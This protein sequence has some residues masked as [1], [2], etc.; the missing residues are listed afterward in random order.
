MSRSHCACWHKAHHLGKE[1]GRPKDVCLS[2]NYGAT[3]LIRA[4][5]A[6]PIS[7]D[8]GM[9]ILQESK[10]AGLAQTGDNVQRK[11]TYICN[12]CGCCCGMMEAI[13][14]GGIRGAIVTSNWLMKVDLDKCKGCGECA[15][16]CPVDAIAMDEEEVP[17]Q[18]KRKWAV[19]DEKVCL[20]CGVCYP[21]CKS[22]AISMSPRPKRVYTPQT[23]FDQRVAMAIERGKLADLLFDAPERLSHRALRRMIA[24]VEK[25]PPFK[26]A[27]AIKP[28]RSAFLNAM[29]KG[30]KQTSG[31]MSKELG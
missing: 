21:A 1:C 11:M 23:V 31:A 27:M 17:G 18:K 6:K 26:A 8:Q 12:C 22:G 28:L 3:T 15:K 13:R 9:R 4:G 19:R 5:L 2:L 20:G 7:N 24:V 16:A 29:V 10:E 25:S 30:A 14:Y